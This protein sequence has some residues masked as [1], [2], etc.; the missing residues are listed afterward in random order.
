M[1]APMVLMLIAAS[2]SLVLGRWNVTCWALALAYFAV[3]AWVW[4]ASPLWPA[5]PVPPTLRPG[6]YFMVDI[7][8]VL[9]IT[10][11]TIALQPREADNYHSGLEHLK[12]FLAAPTFC[13]RLILGVFMLA[14]W[15]GYV[16]HLDNFPQ[17][18]FLWG[19][20]MA[21]FIIAGGEALHRRR[22]AKAPSRKPDSP[23]S[24][25]PKVA[26]ARAGPWST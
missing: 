4:L 9:L 13:D 6:D 1:T 11:K 23:S 18:H 17:W 7:V 10:C 8:T 14:V 15:P 26:W 5:W 24:G 2:A 3:E 22:S 21:Q 25:L 20:A 16:I 19:A 12:L